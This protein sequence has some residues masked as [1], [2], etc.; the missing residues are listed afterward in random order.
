MPVRRPLLVLAALVATAA[1]APAVAAAKPRLTVTPSTVALG[2]PTVIAGRGWPVIEFCRRTV[3]L[4]L[5]SA[6]N[7]V[8][9]AVMRIRDDGRFRYRWTPAPR[10]VGPGRWRVVARQRCESGK[11]GSTIWNVRS[12]KVRLTARP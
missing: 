9:L 4:T 2:S 11:D 12:A 5:R 6:Q 7:A 8:P 3:R 10:R 1:A